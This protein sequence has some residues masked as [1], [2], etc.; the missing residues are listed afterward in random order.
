MEKLQKFNISRILITLFYITFIM[1]GL[2]I[3]FKSIKVFELVITENQYAGISSIIIVFLFVILLLIG[4]NNKIDSLLIPKIYIIYP[5]LLF[6]LAIA[7]R[8]FIILLVGYN[9]NQVSDFSNAYSASLQSPPINN[10][11]YSIFPS[12]G[13]Y[14]SYLHKINEIFGYSPFT[15]ILF[16]CILSSISV[17]LIYYICILSLEK[18]SIA[19]ISAYLYALWPIQLFYNILL[20]PEIINIVLALFSVLLITLGLKT[21]IREHRISQIICFTL[22]GMFLGVSGLFKSIEKIFIIAILIL[23][24]LKFFKRDI[25]DSSEDKEVKGLLKTVKLFLITIIMCVITTRL[26]YVYLNSYI[27]YSVNKNPSPHFLYIGLNHNS[28]G[29][30]STETSIYGDIIEKYNYNFDNANKEM[31]NLIYEDIS[32]NK[33]LSLNFF[34]NKINIAWADNIYYYFID[35]TINNDNIGAI[36]KTA[37]IKAMEPLSQL[38]WCLVILFMTIGILSELLKKGKKSSAILFFA[39]YIFGF[40]LLLLLIEVQERYKCITYPYI[41]IIAAKGID[42]FNYLINKVACSIKK[43]IVLK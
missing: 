9:T 28:R 17:V 12:W 39:L 7:L 2:N 34:D 1:F 35:T 25:F 3:F 14:S 32:N 41:S 37:W 11:Y 5:I 40:A 6:I 27:G 31:M 36:N 13:F 42:Y 29:V 19:L 24:I 10:L 16:N 15:G 22:S 20:S 23:L 21:K 8:F 30:W 26:G 38:F 33:H 18:L 4:Y 43:L